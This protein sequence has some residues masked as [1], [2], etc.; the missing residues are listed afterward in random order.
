MGL[1]LYQ[2]HYIFIFVSMND[3]RY[4][5]KLVLFSFLIFV[6]QLI[7]WIPFEYLRD[8]YSDAFFQS[9]VT[10]NLLVYFISFTFIQIKLKIN[11]LSN[12]ILLSIVQISLSLFVIL[13]TDTAK[14][15][16][17][18]LIF[19]TIFILLNYLI[20]RKTKR[21]ILIQ[22]TLILFLTSISYL[23]YY[24]IGFQLLA[25]HFNDK[26]YSNTNMLHQNFYTINHDSTEIKFPFKLKGKIYFIEFWN[27]NCPSCIKL[28]PDMERLQDY[29]KDDS[30]VE[31]ISCYCP[32]FETDTR[33]WFFNTYLT[34]NKKIPKINYHYVNV[35]TG[36]KLKINSFPHFYLI[37]KNGNGIEGTHMTFNKTFSKNIYERIDLL[38]KK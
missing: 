21:I 6:I 38:K 10:V 28:L 8:D 26:E 15:K 32:V 19:Y 23:F 29:Y 30:L 5:L 1:E 11:E 9:W 7:V 27:K 34:S 36:Q 2:S 25:F 37:D 14:I 3:I 35:L 12:S 16:S 31:I 33:N 13:G 22:S 18:D 4:K 17:V 24:T 20:V